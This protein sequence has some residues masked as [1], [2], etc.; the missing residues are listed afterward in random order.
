MSLGCGLMMSRQHLLF[1]QHQGGREPGSS[2][3]V[4][5]GKAL[6]NVVTK[7]KPKVLLQNGDS[8]ALAQN[9]TALIAG[10]CPLAPR[11]W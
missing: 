7:N 3:W 2:G 11:S 9:L 1:C 10:R 8:R 5:P 6:I 4:N